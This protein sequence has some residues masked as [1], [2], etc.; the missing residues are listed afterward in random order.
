MASL[1]LMVAAISPSDMRL[2]GMEYVPAANAGI[3]TRFAVPVLFDSGKPKPG[4]NEMARL[5][6][7]LKI[8]LECSPER[9]AAEGYASSTRFKHSIWEDG[10][11]CNSDCRNTRLAQLRADNLEI[12]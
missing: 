6:Q 4:H 8:L 12:C 1:G 2:V 7:E 10:V 11:E 5:D 3:S 9:L